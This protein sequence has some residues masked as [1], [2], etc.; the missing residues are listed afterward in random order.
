MK[1]RILLIL[2]PLFVLLLALTTG[3]VLLLRLFAVMAIVLISGYLWAFFGIRGLT[4]QVSNSAEYCQAGDRFE[5][6]ITIFN[7]SW[8]PKLFI[9]TIENTDLPGQHSAASFNLPP[10]GYFQWENSVYCQCRGLYNLGTVT[11]TS[12]DP[13]G[14]FSF[15]RNL[16]ESKSIVVY[17]ATLDLPF[18]QSRSPDSPG[19]D[20]S[21][22]LTSEIGPNAARVREY[23]GGD[24][25]NRIHWRS[26]A[27][28]GKLMVKEFDADSLNYSSKN[29]WIVLDMHQ[30]SQVGEGDNSTEEY[31]VTI[32]ASLIKK[33]INNDKQVGLVSTGDQPYLFLP[34][35]GERHFWDIMEVLAILK[36]AGEVP[37]EKLILDKINNFGSETVLIVI[38]PA[39][40]ERILGPLRQVKN[41][42]A[43]V[44]VI[45][46]DYNSF[47]GITGGVNTSRNLISS[48][49]QVY[50]VRPGES[51]ARALD[52]KVLLPQARFA[53]GVL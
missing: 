21:R 36:A 31:S 29:I 46:L 16:G 26:T 40:G 20:T 18:F 25:L 43:P 50:T 14:F 2:V 48:G 1:R 33:Y 4:G 44:I 38:T 35:T 6:K 8:L 22:W 30:N 3:S 45:S 41:R 52:S 51:L 42:G 11:V 17:P 12:T 49:F 15:H 27:H 10:R 24:T 34:Q 5:Q 19:Y 47:S 23:V 28:T 32:A 13:F 39:S 37:V 9:K 53:G 7:N